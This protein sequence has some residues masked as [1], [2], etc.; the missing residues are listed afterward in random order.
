[1]CYLVVSFIHVMVGVEWI[2][3]GSLGDLVELLGFVHRM[4]SGLHAGSHKVEM[5]SK[6]R[7]SGTVA[8]R[9]DI[10]ADLKVGLVHVTGIEVDNWSAVPDA[11]ELLE[12]GVFV[13]HRLNLVSVAVVDV[14]T[15]VDELVYVV[16]DELREIPNGVLDWWCIRENSGRRQVV[17]SV[18]TV[19]QLRSSPAKRCIDK[20]ARHSCGDGEG[21][22]E[23]QCGL[24][25]PSEQTVV[26]LFDDELLHCADNCLRKGLVDQWLIA[27]EGT[28]L[29]F[30]VVLLWCLFGQYKRRLDG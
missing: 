4:R 19:N 8:S 13:V 16:E 9:Q 5:G 15:W 12:N 24:L 11:V 6:R 3:L 30:G 26:W 28:R 27:V 23:E 17:S 29:A 20:V 21:T 1:M 14:L 2:R 10:A 22:E 18:H 7:R 25:Q